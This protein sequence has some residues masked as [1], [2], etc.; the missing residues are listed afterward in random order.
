MDDYIKLMPA[1]CLDFHCIA[2]K[3]KHTC[4]AGWEIDIDEISLKRYSSEQGELGIKLASNIENGAF[5]LGEDERCPFLNSRNLCDLILAK[6]EN[7]LCDI[8]KE[9]PRFYNYRGDTEE[10]G[11][12]LCCEEAA[13]IILGAEDRSIIVLNGQLSSEEAK[14]LKRRENFILSLAAQLLCSNPTSENF[15]LFFLCENLDSEWPDILKKASQLQNYV[16]PSDKGCTL[17]IMNLVAY[18]VYRYWNES[19]EYGED[20]LQRFVKDCVNVVKAVY[21]VRAGDRKFD[22]ELFCDTARLFSSEIEY[23]DINTGLWFR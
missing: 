21:V 18:L 8:C 15:D 1:Y 3:C 19:I 2:D 6:G 7:Y 14:L 5:R 23:S 9:H 11:I 22:F 17:A 12:G 20:K 13:R 4:C 16:N 10:S